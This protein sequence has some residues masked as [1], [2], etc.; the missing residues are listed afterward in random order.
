MLTMNTITSKRQERADL[1]AQAR[2]ILDASQDKGLSK[3]EQARW[4]QL[5][6]EVEQLGDQI[7]RLERQRD[8]ENDLE[9]RANDCRAGRE[10]IIPGRM[11]SRREL[12]AFSNYLKHGLAGLSAEHRNIMIG[13]FDPHFGIQM[14]QGVGTDSA[15][16]FVVPDAPMQTVLEAMKA[17]GGIAP[18]ATTIETPTGADMPIPTD[19]DT[20]NVGEIIAENAQHNEQDVVF[21][22]TVLKSYLYSSKIVRVSWQ[23]MDDANMNFANYVARK[24]GERLGRITSTHFI[25]GTGTGQPTGLLATTG[26]ATTGVT[27]AATGVVTYDELVDLVASVDPAYVTNARWVMNHTTLQEIRKLKDSQQRPLFGP[28][29]AAGTPNSLLGF[30][31]VVDQGMPSMA[32]S[33][34]AI[35]FGDLGTYHIRRVRGVRILRLEERYADYGQ[36]AFIGFIRLD[37]ALMDA[38]TNPIKVLV[39]AAS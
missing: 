28:D 38:G 30:P 19:N 35:A 15:G 25:S 8:V 18:F 37:A 7:Q 14:A 11:E 4:D 31:V 20:S 16:G 5:M 9:Q 6:G 32:A 34:K 17:F 39:M 36:V 29:V 10:D 22:Q 21:A 24:L 2:S 3:S 23:L 26:G 27:A 12:E 13:R 33:A 1:V